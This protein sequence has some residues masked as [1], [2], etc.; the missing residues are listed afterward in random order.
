MDEIPSF[1]RHPEVPGLHVAFHRTFD[2]PLLVVVRRLEGGALETSALPPKFNP[3]ALA[4]APSLADGEWRFGPLGPDSAFGRD[5]GLAVVSS[6]H[7][8]WR[9]AIDWKRT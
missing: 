1:S 8:K 4:S 5:Y 2:M 3:Q 6:E 9:R 7:E